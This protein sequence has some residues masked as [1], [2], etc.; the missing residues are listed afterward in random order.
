MLILGAHYGNCKASYEAPLWWQHVI[1]GVPHKKLCNYHKSCLHER[2]ILLCTLVWPWVGPTVLSHLFQTSW[3]IIFNSA[4]RDVQTLTLCCSCM[5]VLFNNFIVASYISRPS[6]VRKEKSG[7]PGWYGDVIWC[8]WVSPPTHSHS[9]CGSG[10]PRWLTTWS[11]GWRYVT[12]PQTASDYI[13]KST[14]PS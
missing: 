8:G 13:T 10:L 7:R 11:S 3:M 12:M 1:T 5:Q 9:V 6:Q 2:Y 14:R 4:T